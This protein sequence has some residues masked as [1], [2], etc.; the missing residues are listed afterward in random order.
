MSKQEKDLLKSVIAIA[1]ILVVM[2]IVGRMDYDDQVRAV[3]VYCENVEAGIWPDYDRIYD[4][5]CKK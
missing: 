5:E 2:G 1:L 3:E 4:K